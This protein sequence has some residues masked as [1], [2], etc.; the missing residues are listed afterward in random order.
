MLSFF[1]HVY[2]SAVMYSCVSNRYNGGISNLIIL[3]G[4]ISFSLMMLMSILVPETFGWSPFFGIA[5]ILSLNA[6]FTRND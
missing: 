3:S 6:E 4:P 5:L 1:L 2:N